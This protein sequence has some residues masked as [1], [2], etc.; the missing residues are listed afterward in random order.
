MNKVWED[1][2]IPVFWNLKTDQ[3]VYNE[4]C[5]VVF[6]VCLFFFLSGVAFIHL[7][8][9]YG[10]KGIEDVQPVAYWTGEGPLIVWEGERDEAP[11]EKSLEPSGQEA[12]P[13]TFQERIKHL[14]ETRDLHFHAQPH[15]PTSPSTGVLEMTHHE[16]R[17]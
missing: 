9:Y 2:S 3:N 5:V 17:V 7:W 16:V 1:F 8:R 10:Y 11:L 6:F 12:G 4:M 14:R 15:S 13:A